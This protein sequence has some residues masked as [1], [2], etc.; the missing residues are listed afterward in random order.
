M[1]R[2]DSGELCK[3]NNDHQGRL[4]AWIKTVWSGSERTW[5]NLLRKLPGFYPLDVWQSLERCG[6]EANL[7]TLNSQGV[8]RQ[9]YPEPFPGSLEHPLD[10]EWRF[11]QESIGGVLDVLRIAASDRQ[12]LSIV[13]LGC[14]SIVAAGEKALPTWEW[15]LLDRRAHL[16][17]STTSR[18]VR[19]DL[20]KEAPDIP[21]QDVAVVDPPWYTPITKHFLAKAQMLVKP[22]GIVLLSFPP[23]GTRA[24]AK[25]E[26]DELINWCNQRGLNLMQSSAARLFYKTP[27]FEWNSLRAAGFRARVPAWRSADLLMFKRQ[28]GT[29]VD[30]TYDEQVPQIFS[31]EWQEFL[32]NGI[33]ICVNTNSTRNE[34]AEIPS[35]GLKPVWQEEV[36][37]TVSTKFPGRSNANIVT[38]GNR[39]FYCCEP[40]IVSDALSSLAND[41]GKNQANNSR[42]N[43]VEEIA[44]VVESEISDR[45]D[46]LTY[47]YD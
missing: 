41:G 5:E 26:L 13:C 2:F 7:L 34:T 15:T 46:Y 32:I 21:L 25:N 35:K 6:L 22:G 3:S 29:K 4:D 37:P 39:F 33:K 20:T 47:M 19:C 45:S 24:R 31:S 44:K 18:L 38:S 1:W 30:L 10:Y 40:S 12:Q 11:T 27:F 28:D 42:I 23:E 14:P 9:M 17:Q 16:L 8:A 43:Y 36:L